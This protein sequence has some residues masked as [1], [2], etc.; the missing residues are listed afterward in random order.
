M[1]KPLEFMARRENWNLGISL[2]A[3]QM[4]SD[5]D[6]YTAQPVVF[7]EAEEGMNWGINKNTGVKPEFF[8]VAG[9]KKY[10]H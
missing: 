10:G 6:F 5:K 8:S 7:E 1:N 9:I 4:Y 3:R 2:Y